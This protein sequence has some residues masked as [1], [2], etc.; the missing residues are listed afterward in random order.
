MWVNMFN[1]AAF[2]HIWVLFRSKLTV[3][4]F[5][6]GGSRWCTSWTHHILGEFQRRHC[7]PD[8]CLYRQYFGLMR[9]ILL[10]FV[11][12]PGSE[13][14]PQTSWLGSK[15]DGPSQSCHDRELQCQICLA[16]CSQKVVCI[17]CPFLCVCKHKTGF[18]L[19]FLSSI[20]SNRAALHLYSNTLKFQ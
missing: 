19:N 1:L 17:N 2:G 13:A 5:Q 15:V 12:L 9:M 16:S 14:L 11:C 20:C 7:C 4:H 10:T 6:G 8:V 3:N 18:H